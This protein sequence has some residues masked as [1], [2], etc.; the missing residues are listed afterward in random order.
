MCWKAV[1][2]SA[3]LGTTGYNFVSGLSGTQPNLC[4]FVTTAVTPTPTPTPTGTPN[5][6]TGCAPDYI[7]LGGI[8]STDPTT[9]IFNNRIYVFTTG[10]DGSIYYQYSSNTTFSGWNNLGGGTS[11]ASMSIVVGS[12]LYVEVIGTD[13]KHYYKSSTDGLTFSAWTEG[14]VNAQT[15]PVTVFSGKTYTFVKG[16]NNT[17]NLC[18]KIQ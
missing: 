8:I 10:T 12:T 15:N 11:S 1:N 13:S 14:T 6:S 7:S 3:I 5:T 4:T 2:S 9:S 18:V 17:P 16:V